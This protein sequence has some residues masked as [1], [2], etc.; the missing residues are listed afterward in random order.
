MF[1]NPENCPEEGKLGK[2]YLIIECKRHE[3]TEN[4]TEKHQRQL[5]GQMLCVAGYMHKNKLW[6]W[7]NGSLTIVGILCLNGVLHFYKAEFTNDYL[8]GLSNI[9]INGLSLTVLRYV[10]TQNLDLKDDAQRPQ[11]VEFLLRLRTLFGTA[12]P[13]LTG[14]DEEDN[15]DDDDGDQDDDHKVGEQTRKLN[16][17]NI[18]QTSTAPR[19]CG[20]CKQTG[21]DR[22][23]C[24]VK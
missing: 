11:A 19:M 18:H 6:I 1:L 24:T 3:A 17:L 21:H 10:H 14:D 4:A 16:Q 13:V 20:N 22:Q 9:T 5:L 12:P 15:D 23:N 7:E 8:N 2:G